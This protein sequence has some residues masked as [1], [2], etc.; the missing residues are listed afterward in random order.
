M[1]QWPTPLP[2]NGRVGRATAKFAGCLVLAIPYEGQE[3]DGDEFW[4]WVVQ[5]APEPALLQ[6]LYLPRTIFVEFL[7]DAQ[8]DWI[9]VDEDAAIESKYFGF[10]GEQTGKIR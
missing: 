4:V 3:P 2:A 5:P 7:D 8:I 1:T 6:D 10:R 9:P